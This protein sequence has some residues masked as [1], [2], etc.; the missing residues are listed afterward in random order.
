[1]TSMLF[2]P[3]MRTFHPEHNREV[4][5]LSETRVVPRSR[6]PRLP[7]LGLLLRARLL[8]VL[9]Y[10]LW[11][12]LVPVREPHE[13]AP[14][15]LVDLNPA[16][17]LVVVR[18]ELDGRDDATERDALDLLEAGLHI[19]AGDLAVGLRLQGIPDRLDLEGRPHD[20]PVVIHGGRNLLRRLLPL[21]FVHLFDL[22]DH[23]EVLADAG[24][25]D[26]VVPLG[27]APAARRLDVGL[28]RAPDERH[29]L[30]ERIADALQLLDRDGWRPPEEMGNHEDS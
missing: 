12:G 6:A 28:G 18:R 10:N 22:L 16:A 14:L 5:G 4:G 1:M 23:G 2:S 25:L 15:R 9:R 3:S 26:G 27:H 19:L 13:L 17:P 29:D 21:L 30:P 7:G 24:E 20:A 11:I 8:D